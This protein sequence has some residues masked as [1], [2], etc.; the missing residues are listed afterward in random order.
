MNYDSPAKRDMR[1]SIA[2][3]IL[4]PQV[5]MFREVI[6]IVSYRKVPSTLSYHRS[7]ELRGS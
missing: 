3:A 4:V 2:Q 6:V 7:V 5:E 1:Y